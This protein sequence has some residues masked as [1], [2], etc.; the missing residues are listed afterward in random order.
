MGRQLYGDPALAIREL[1]QNALDAC[2]WRDTRQQ[3]LERTSQAPASWAGRLRFTQGIDPSGRPYIDCEDNGVGMDFNTLEHVFGNAGER[4]VYQQEFR[5]EQAAWAELDPPLGM[6]SNSQF[7]VGVFSYFM[8][9]DEIT[10]HT[11]HQSRYGIPDQEA[12]E[13]S[14]ASSG[15]LF[16]IQPAQGLASGGTRVRLYLSGEASAYPS[17]VRSAN[18]SGYPNFGSRSPRE[19][20][21]RFG[22]PA[23]FVYPEATVLPCRFGEHLWWVSGDGGLAADGIRT[24]EELFGLD[25]QSPRRA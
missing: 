22:S 18:C 2:R 24:N 23:S 21:A 25:N 3:Y 19:R 5:T 1:Y 10:V 9:A 14:I 11:R 16:Q 15:S 12:Y 17:F 7:G 20:T 13:V 8:L 4:F 6:I